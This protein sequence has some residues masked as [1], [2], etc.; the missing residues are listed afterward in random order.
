MAT[1]FKVTLEWTQRGA[2]N[3]IEASGVAEDFTDLPDAAKTVLG[4]ALT[5]IYSDVVLATLEKPTMGEPYM[6]EVDGMREALQATKDAHRQCQLTL[7]S[8]RGRLYDAQIARNE[9]LAARDEAL[10]EA[11][12]EPDEAQSVA[13]VTEAQQISDEA[14]DAAL[15]QDRLNAVSSLHSTKAKSKKPTKKTK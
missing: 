5:A 6:A 1:T 2:K 15:E 9:A 13:S 14:R 3:I 7:D 10:G 8:A 4:R 12:S 11:L